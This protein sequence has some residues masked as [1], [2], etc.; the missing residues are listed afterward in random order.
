MSTAA[1]FATGDTRANYTQDILREIDANRDNAVVGGVLVSETDEVRVWH[2]TLRAG[3][4]CGFHRHVLDYFW[5]CHCDGRAR[6]YFEDGT[7]REDTYYAGETRHMKFA[8][9]EY[10]LHALENKGSADLTFTV[11]EFIKTSA[12]APL[13]VPDEVRLKVPKAA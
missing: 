1:S 8:P 6:N 11:V 9:G 12:N 13:P 10:M 7:T 2:L 5:T 3:Q 4:R